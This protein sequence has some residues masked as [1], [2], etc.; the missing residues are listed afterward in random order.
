MVALIYEL[1]ISG[2]SILIPMFEASETYFEIL[3]CDPCAE[4]I[5]EL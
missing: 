2:D 5:I 4:E 3:S 1:L